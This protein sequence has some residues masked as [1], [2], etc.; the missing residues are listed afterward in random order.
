M[1]KLQRVHIFYYFFTSV[2]PRPRL[3]FYE[4]NLT[5]TMKKS[6]PFHTRQGQNLNIII[7]LQVVV[8]YLT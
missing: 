4:E 6:T 3:I 1:Y 8:L 5:H 2:R 7:V